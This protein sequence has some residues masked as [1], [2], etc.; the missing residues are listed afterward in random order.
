MFE[1]IVGGT[2]RFVKK[3]LSSSKAILSD[4]PMELSDIPILG[5]HF[6]ESTRRKIKKEFNELYKNSGRNS[7]GKETNKKFRSMY[8]ELLKD[9]KKNSEITPKERIQR[10]NSLTKKYDSYMSNQIRLRESRKK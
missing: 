9:N 7:Y 5:G 4:A 1:A 2:G 6:G 3:S 8:K 10:A